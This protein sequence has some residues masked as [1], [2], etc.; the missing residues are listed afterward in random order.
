MTPQLQAIA[1]ELR[2]A[3]RRLHRLAHDVPAERWQRRPA[4]DRWSVAECV[5]HL[6]LTGEAYVPILRA[7]IQKARAE[8][9]TGAGPFRRD[10]LGWVLWRTM[11]PPVRFMLTRTA[12]PFVPTGGRAPAELL[13][14]FDALQEEQ[15]DCVRAGDGLALDRIRIASPF[16]PR[17]RYNLYAAFSILPRHQERHI[18]Q[19]ERAAGEP[20]GRPAGEQAGPAAGEPPEGEQDD[21]APGEVG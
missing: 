15:L 5:E 2:A 9:R 10:P 3:Q 17:A 16:D 1:D 6:N 20:A 8:G 18:W 11:A 13:E 7:A 4:P 21:R 14:R 12:P 19:A